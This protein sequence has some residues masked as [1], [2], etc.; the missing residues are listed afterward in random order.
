MK[1]VDHTM[2]SKNKLEKIETDQIFNWWPDNRTQ[3]RMQI[4]LAYE[5]KLKENERNAIF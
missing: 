3:K 4:I 2:V 1:Y 5:N